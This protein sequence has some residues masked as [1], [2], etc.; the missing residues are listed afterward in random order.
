MKLWRELKRIV[1]DREYSIV[2]FWSATAGI[3]GMYVCQFLSDRYIADL[4][5]DIDLGVLRQYVQGNWV[6][7]WV[8]EILGCW[9]GLRSNRYRHSTKTAIYLAVILPLIFA[10]IAWVWRLFDYEPLGWGT[11]ISLI[12]S[13]LTILIV[14][15]LVARYLSHLYSSQP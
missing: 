14:P 7:L 4:F 11:I 9:W 8:G 6:G 3:I 15:G 13:G 10:A 12:V 2:M 5:A 1:N